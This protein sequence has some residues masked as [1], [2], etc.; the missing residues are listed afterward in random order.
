MIF[1]TTTEYA[2]RGLAELAGRAGD[3]RS[4][5]LDELVSDTSLPR[6]FL[7]KVFQR[8]VKAGLLRSAKGRGGGFALGRPANE[9]TLKDIVEAIDGPLT[10]DRCA[11]GLDKCSDQQP[12][13]QHDLY[14]PIRQRIKEYLQTTT[15]ADLSSSLKTKA[16][17]LKAVAARDEAKARTAAL[18][19]T[20]TATS[21]GLA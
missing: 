2:I 18:A 20:S 11:V 12:C 3:G 9:I 21:G 7:A 4:M 13:P 8:L 16:A 17:W 19:A 1:T 5:M 6:D 15:V 10:F 14:K